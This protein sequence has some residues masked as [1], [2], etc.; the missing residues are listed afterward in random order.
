MAWR[1]RA[2]LILCVHLW[3]LGITVSTFM[4]ILPGSYMSPVTAQ[5]A[6]LDCKYVAM[7]GVLLKQLYCCADED[8]SIESGK[9]PP[10]GH[11]H[12]TRPPKPTRQASNLDMDPEEAAKEN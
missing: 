8:T 1:S 2:Q 10:N 3:L 7:L 5:L 6:F 12:R 4:C 9:R 11:D